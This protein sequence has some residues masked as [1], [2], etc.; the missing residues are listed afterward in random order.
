MKTDF[1][2]SL[3][4]YQARRGEIR[5]VEVPPLRY[6]MVDGHG[7]PNSAPEYAEALAV[8]YPLAYALKFALRQPVQRR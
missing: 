6:L 3:D 4:S 8:L 5:L 2:T 7:D 1:R